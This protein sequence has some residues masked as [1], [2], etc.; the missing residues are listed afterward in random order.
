MVQ[1]MEAAK[2]AIATNYFLHVEILL[3]AF[4]SPNRYK[5]PKNMLLAPKQL[6]CFLEMSQVYYTALHPCCTA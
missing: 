2:R 1:F 6:L 5:R 3:L 4:T